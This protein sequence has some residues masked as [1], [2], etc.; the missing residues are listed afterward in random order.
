MQWNLL[1][2][3]WTLFFADSLGALAGCMSGTRRTW[4]T[5]H[6][7]GIAATLP[8]STGW[9]W[10]YFTLAILGLLTAASYVPC[11]DPD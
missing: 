10:L 8:L 4:Y 7:P 9:A 3:I 1:A 6:F 2:V 5:K 11:D